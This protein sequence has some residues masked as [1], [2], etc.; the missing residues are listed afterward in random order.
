MGLL[1]IYK[2]HL[3]QNK[4]TG[5]RNGY[6]RHSLTAPAPVKFCHCE[7]SG[8]DIKCAE[9]S[10]KFCE[11][12]EKDLTVMKRKYKCLSLLFMAYYC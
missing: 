2:K 5:T 4:C 3:K 7:N 11:S 8:H 9:I 12:A 10:D 6:R 1:P